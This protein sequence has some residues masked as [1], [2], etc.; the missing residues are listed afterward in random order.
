MRT[1][2][3]TEPRRGRMVRR[4]ARDVTE[5]GR[6]TMAGRCWDETETGRGSTVR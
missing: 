2:D 4:R 5:L 6:G 1:R 3:E